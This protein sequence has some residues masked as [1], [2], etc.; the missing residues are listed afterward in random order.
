MNFIT[1]W[2]DK[3]EQ[4]LT[5]NMP[6]GIGIATRTIIVAVIIFSL[7]ILADL[8]TRKIILSGIT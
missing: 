8:I 5:T 7:A 6:E 1:Q 2:V 4:L 3:L